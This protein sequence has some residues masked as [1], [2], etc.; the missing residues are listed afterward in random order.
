[1]K[2]YILWLMLIPLPLP[3]S[4][5]EAPLFRQLEKYEKNVSSLKKEI[6]SLEKQLGDTNKRYITVLE[7]RKSLENM[8]EKQ[9]NDLQVNQ[10]KLKKLSTHVKK[11]IQ[12]L[13]IHSMGLSKGGWGEISSRSVIK[14]SLKIKL[15]KLEQ[16]KQ[17]N[18]ELTKK[19][20]NIHQKYREYL[21]IEE[22]ILNLLRDWEYYKQEKTQDYVSQKKKLQMVRSQYKSPA[23][24]RDIL[25]DNPIDQYINIKH[26][27]KGVTYYT[28]GYQKIKNA[29]PGK[30]VYSNKLSTFGNVV[31]VD[32]GDNIRSIFLGKFSP[33]VKKGMR[34]KM[35]DILGY[36][37]KLEKKPTKIYFEIRKKNKAQNTI[38]FIDKKSLTKARLEKS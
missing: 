3:A 19:M 29:R 13:I 26:G 12:S 15:K 31:M 28:R 14:K 2:Y 25:F 27:K 11:L 34:V 17:K 35:G 22:G 10:D 24:L 30:I 6:S 20:A 32:H 18:K 8:I 33:K 23:K 21:D 16:G 1:M 7:R 36:T 37:T 5:P 9:K 4:I 38:L